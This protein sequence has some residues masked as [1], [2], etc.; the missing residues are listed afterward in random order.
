MLANT[1]R[2]SIKTAAAVAAAGFMLAVG[3][4]LC[5]QVALTRLGLTE[6]AARAFLLDEIKGPALDRRSSIAVAGTRAFLKLP[7][8]ARAEAATGLFAWAKTYV[9]SPAF[10]SSYDGHRKDRISAEP[11]YAMPV[12]DTLKKEMDETRAGIEIMKKNLAASGLPPVEQQKI[13]AAWDEAQAKANAPEFVA[14]RQ[15]L[16][17][18]EREEA[19]ANHARYMAEIEHQTPT[20]PQKLFARRLREFLDLTADVNFSSKT[21][22][23]TGGPDGIEFL[24]K[25]DRE[26]HWIWQEA[27]I[28]G[29]EATAAAR[30]A[31]QTWLK[32]IQ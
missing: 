18:A 25:A 14:S 8:S 9:N 17:A 1:N 10:K 30:A 16:L 12:E 31:A 13:L 21:I 26:R 28:V 23:L 32:E 6:T 24:D 27:V 3:G 22:S 7:P 15:K 29:P 5:A 4:Q 11:K 20:D 19:R 2:K